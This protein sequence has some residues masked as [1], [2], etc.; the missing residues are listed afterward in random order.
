MSENGVLR[1]VFGP[2]REDVTGSMRNS[3]SEEFRNLYASVV[4]VP[5]FN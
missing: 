2:N 5:F 3:H 1:R 4:P